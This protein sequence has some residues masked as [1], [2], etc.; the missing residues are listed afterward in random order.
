[1]FAH[2]RKEREYPPKPCYSCK[3]EENASNP[4]KLKGSG[5]IVW[6][7]GEGGDGNGAGRG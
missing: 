3:P 1:M 5:K 7:V 6:A 2:G 4:R